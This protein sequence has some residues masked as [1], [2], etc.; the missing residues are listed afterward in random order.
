MPIVSACPS[1]SELKLSNHAFNDS[2]SLNIS[3]EAL[4]L[5]VH[6]AQLRPSV[7]RRTLA[8][9]QVRLRVQ[10]LRSPRLG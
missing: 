4:N 10:G 2:A 9:P 8:P 5:E 3:I 1:I 7:S 6:A